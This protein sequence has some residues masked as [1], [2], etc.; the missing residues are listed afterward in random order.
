MLKFYFFIQP[1]NFRIYPGSLIKTP[2]ET[3]VN[4]E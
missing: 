2:G 4:K 1:K 3:E